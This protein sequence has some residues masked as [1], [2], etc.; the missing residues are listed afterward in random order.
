MLVQSFIEFD[1]DQIL[2]LIPQDLQPGK[3]CLLLKIHKPSN[4]GR[5][6]VSN[7]R[8]LTEKISQYVEF[9]LKPYAQ[10]VNSFIQ[11]TTDFLNK[12]KNVSHLPNNTL[13]VTLDVC[14]LYTNISHSNGLSVLKNKLPNNETTSIILQL[15]KFI[16]EHN[17]FKFQDE[18][19]LQIKSTA[20]G[21]PMAAQYANIFRAHLEKE[22]WKN[23]LKNQFFIYAILMIFSRF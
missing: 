8:T 18:H 19:Y 7:K 11:D 6:I 23:Q 3:S 2:K 20:M 16:L 5:P 10:D 9:H 22:F 13:L 1:Q 17:H 12:L 14:S 21:P 4:P 15:T